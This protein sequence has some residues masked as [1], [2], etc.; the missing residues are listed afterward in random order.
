MN[1]RR[2]SLAAVAAP[3]AR[4][5]ADWAWRVLAL[6]LAASA[7]FPAAT[8]AREAPSR[9]RPDGIEGAMV[10][11]GGAP[12]AESAA[13]Q[14]VDL[15]GKEKAHIVVLALA[16]ADRRLAE[17]D[18]KLW[19]QHRAASVKLRSLANQPI[20]AG[21]LGG[22]A[23][24][25]WLA[26]HLT[27]SSI[28]AAKGAALAKELVAVLQHGGV[29]GGRSA[30]MAMLSRW[31]LPDDRRA[32]DDKPIA[33][34]DLLPGTALLPDFHRGDARVHLVR[35][36]RAHPDAVGLGISDGA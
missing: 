9:L 26:G 32:E 36:L 33:G 21:E 1:R 12:V 35:L 25:V 2:F 7:T 11:T 8:S 10:I 20:R 16:D 34:L 13:W 19:T 17:E 27:A 22:K 30:A 4:L 23:T 5:S 3:L 24:G 31:T 28:E 18:V 6:L 29:I 15:A 14:F